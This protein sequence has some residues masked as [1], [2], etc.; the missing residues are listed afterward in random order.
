M[1][2]Y[3]ELHEE[4]FDRVASVGMVEHVGVSRLGEYFA[5]AHRL[6]RPGGLFLNHGIAPLVPRDGSLRSKLL[7]QGGFL[8]RY[9]FPDSELPFLHETGEAA[10][11]AGLE[12]RDVESLREHYALTLRHWLSRLERQRDEAIRSVGPTAFR[13]WRL[14]M[15]GGAAEFERGQNGVYQALFVRRDRGKSG[16]PLTR[17]DWYAQPLVD[18]EPD[19]RRAKG[20]STRAAARRKSPPRRR[21][22]TPLSS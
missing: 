19:A 5:N 22:K 20:T 18:R 2:D 13:I 21:R 9:V 15:A 12:L 3:R 7:R 8:Q 11:Q 4:P 10:V 6:L 1:V 16:L 14:Y 17:D